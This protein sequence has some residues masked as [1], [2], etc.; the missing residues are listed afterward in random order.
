MDRLLRWA[1]QVEGRGAC[2]LPNGAVR[3]L[4]SG[5]AVFA[6]EVGR[7]RSGAGCSADFNRSGG[8]AVLPIPDTR[9][10]PWQ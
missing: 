5:L 9:S 10:E 3:L 8:P 1:G 2:H 6:D 4:R 7:H